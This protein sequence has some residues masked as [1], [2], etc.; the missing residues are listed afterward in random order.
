MEGTLVFDDDEPGNPPSN[1]PSFTVP[2]FEYPHGAGGGFS[3]TGGY[4]VR[5]P[6]AGAQGL[7]IFADFVSNNI[8]TSRA[9]PAG[10]QNVTL[11][12]AQFV[13]S[14]GTLNQIASFALD[15]S[16]RVYTVGLERRGRQ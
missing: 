2:I 5:G 11:R 4:V 12:N 9:G 13:I 1:D 10:A 7:Y 6:D 14:G 8:W 15:G 16:E 3:V